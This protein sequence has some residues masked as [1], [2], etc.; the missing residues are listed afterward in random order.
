MGAMKVSRDLMAAR[1]SGGGRLVSSKLSSGATIRMSAIAFTMTPA[2]HTLSRR[3]PRNREATISRMLPS[4]KA[5]K[6]AFTAVARIQAGER[7]ARCQRV[8]QG[9]AFEEVTSIGSFRQ[10]PD[11]PHPY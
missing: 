5:R 1:D 6:A 10:R 7:V 2:L 4:S 11:A 9:T 3:K 8:G